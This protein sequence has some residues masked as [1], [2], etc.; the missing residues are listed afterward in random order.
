VTG[1]APLYETAANYS[2]QQAGWC[3]GLMLMET[4]IRH[5]AQ[6]FCK[7]DPEFTEGT[8]YWKA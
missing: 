2:E 7:K 5:D 3:F 4:M 8:I 6:W 1:P